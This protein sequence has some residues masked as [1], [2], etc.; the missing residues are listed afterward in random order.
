M[1]KRGKETNMPREDTTGWDAFWITTLDEG[2]H[3]WLWDLF[4]D[5][6]NF[7]PEASRDERLQAAETAARRLIADGWAELRAPG[8][9]LVTDGAE[10]EA[11]L[12]RGEWRSFPP[13][14]DNDYELVPTEKWNIW[15]IEARSAR[16]SGDV[17]VHRD[18]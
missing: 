6:N 3:I 2:G 7:F 13:A 4:G 18:A 11:I 15:S 12:T 17:S 5:T 14:P 10:R 9:G 8:G 1:G 16:G